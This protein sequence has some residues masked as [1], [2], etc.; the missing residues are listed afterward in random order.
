RLAPQRARGLRPPTGAGAA[1]GGHTGS[2]LGRDHARVPAAGHLRVGA[3]APS[4]GRCRGSGLMQIPSSAAFSPLPE[5]IAEFGIPNPFEIL[6]LLQNELEQ[7]DTSTATWDG[8]ATDLDSLA[9]D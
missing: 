8:L 5:L 9:D 2:A 6:D 1:A 3:G 4:R 7:V